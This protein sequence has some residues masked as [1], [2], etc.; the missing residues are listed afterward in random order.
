MENVVRGFWSVLNSE[1]FGEIIGFYTAILLFISALAII[2]MGGGLVVKK[3]IN[4]MD[5]E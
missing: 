1:M 2:F 4:H 5:K 3:F